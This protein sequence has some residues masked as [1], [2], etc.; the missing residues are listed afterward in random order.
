MTQFETTGNTN[1]SVQTLAS[2]PQPGPGR[3]E[4]RETDITCGHRQLSIILTWQ[5]NSAWVQLTESVTNE[6]GMP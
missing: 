5:S 4:L 6:L 3:P 2:Q 1:C